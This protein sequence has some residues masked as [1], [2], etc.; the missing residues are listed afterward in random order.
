MRRRTATLVYLLNQ[1]VSVVIL[2]VRGI[3]IVPLFVHYIDIA[4]YGAWMACGNIVAWISMSEGGTSLLLQQ[5]TARAFG[6]VAHDELS[7]VIGSGIL[8]VFVLSAAACAFGLGLSPFVST[9]LGLQGGEA[10]ELS[11]AFS[12][13]VV[14]MAASWIWGAPRSVLQG[15]QRHLAIGITSVS[16]ESASIVVTIVLLYKGWGLISIPIGMVFRELLNNLVLWPIFV[17]A[18]KRVKVR[19]SVSRSQ[20]LSLL[21]LMGWTSLNRLGSSLIK[22]CDAFLISMFLGNRMVPV[23]IFTKRA[24]DIL[25]VFVNRLSFSFVPGLSHLHSADGPAAYQ[26]LT[27][28]LLTV[29]TAS[30]GVGTGIAWGLNESFIQ[31]WLGHDFFAGRVYNSLLGVATFVGVIA[32]TVSQILLSANNIRGSAIGQTG[33]N[34]ARLLVLLLTISYV[35]I[36]SIPIS[37]ILAFIFVGAPY[38]LRQWRKTLGFS[39]R[40][41]GL[42]LWVIGRAV[43]IA[44]I[45]GLIWSTYVPLAESW[46]LLVGQGVALL[47]ILLAAYYAVDPAI[48][49]EMRNLIGFVG[50]YVGRSAKRDG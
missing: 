37:T 32:F 8:L 26:A 15:F 28:R 33:M 9:W 17:I 34:V 30:I 43:A 3:I 41:M 10:S 50:R 7:Q 48:R 13:A 21:K 38:F 1:Y 29:V 45:L 19:P 12:L 49:G 14:A 18:L 46:L 6:K 22:N 4:L 40:Q 42:Q 24:W 16:A 27:N 35:E 44:V 5:Q 20:T 36:L 2:I 47:A 39:D 11:K 23:A 31:L 25:V